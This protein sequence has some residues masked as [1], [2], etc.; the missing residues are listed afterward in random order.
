MLKRLS[1]ILIVLMAASVAHAQMGGG[2]GGGRG[3]GGRGGGGGGGGSKP[4]SAP[5]TPSAPRAR[6]TPVNQI[7]IV[8]VVKEIDTQTGRV[9]IAYDPVE[10]IN[11]PAGSQPFPVAKSALLGA[12]TVGQKVRFTLDS[13]QISTLT[14]FDAPR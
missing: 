4:S 10:A 6:A 7:Q 14:P 13:G 8:G 11:W 1:L 2:G 5:A 12:A 9:T 3:G